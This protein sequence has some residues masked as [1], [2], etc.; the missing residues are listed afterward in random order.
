MP[1]LCTFLAWKE[2]N[3][4]FIFTQLTTATVS[5][6]WLVGLDIKIWKVTSNIFRTIIVVF[7]SYKSAHTQRAE[8]VSWHWGS[9]VALQLW[10]FSLGLAPS[11]PSH[12]QFGR[13]KLWNHA[14][15]PRQ[16]F[17]YGLR[18]I[19][20]IPSVYTLDI[21][22]LLCS[23]QTACFYLWLGSATFSGNAEVTFSSIVKILPGLR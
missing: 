3:L 20:Y 18:I 5:G 2:T 13:K 16:L 9:R 14:V 23:N 7:F 17:V 12:L 22:W 4:P 6:R 10:I 8:S 19:L 11:D 15:V 1:S 21:R